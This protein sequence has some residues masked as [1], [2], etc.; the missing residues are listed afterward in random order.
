MFEVQGRNFR[1]ARYWHSLSDQI[2]MEP[3]YQRAGGI[4][5][6]KDQSYLIDSIINDYD[7]PKL[8]IADFTTLPSSLNTER[9]RFAVI[10]GKQR[11]EAIFSFLSDE[12]PLS[13]KTF[14]VDL[15][16]KDLGGLYFSDLEKLY[17]NIASKVAEF[18]MPI[19]HVVTDELE[20]INELFVRL[21]RG[22]NLTGAERRNAMI[23]PV[24]KAIRKL[25]Q[26]PFFTSK[27]KYKANRGQ[28]L[29]AAA[30]FL[31]FELQGEPVD[32]K[33]RQLDEMV[34]G[35]T[36]E[37]AAK[38]DA[39]IGRVV[40]KLDRMMLTFKDGDPLLASQGNVPVYYLFT[41]SIS[42]TGSE[43]REFLLNFEREL[44]ETR[45]IKDGRSAVFVTYDNAMRS[46][47]DGWS[48]EARLKLLLAQFKARPTADAD[49]LSLG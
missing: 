2:D 34:L 3:E 12:M 10:D 28:N 5:S 8:Y 14:A 25:S 24:P 1:S 29:N 7:I 39:A 13:K 41:S 11:L 30:K 15:S 42:E 21:N 44:R 26:H 18:P 9:K 35:H 6:E 16:G 20:R 31:R 27:T 22:S 49:T 40:A 43:V 37:D 38:L 45:K 48:Y 36:V 33:K 32:T 19:M 4:W 46:T 17:P 47:N 23:G